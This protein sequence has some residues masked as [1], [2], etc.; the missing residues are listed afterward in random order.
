MYIRTKT[1]KMLVSLRNRKTDAGAV[2]ALSGFY[3]P[4]KSI[5]CVVEVTVQWCE[6][7]MKFLETHSNLEL[8]TLNRRLKAVYDQN[9]YFWRSSSWRIRDRVAVYNYPISATYI[10]AHFGNEA[11]Q[12]QSGE[13]VVISAKENV[14][15]LPLNQLEV[16]RLTKLTGKMSHL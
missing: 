11:K 2:D 12:I 15:K 10:T 8:V 5:Q 7:E 6:C 3:F 14:F 16:L 9:E 4:W 13:S 1:A